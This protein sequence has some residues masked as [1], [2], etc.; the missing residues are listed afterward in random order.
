MSDESKSGW[1]RSVWAFPARD[2]ASPAGLPI[3]RKSGPGGTSTLCSSL[4]SRS[5]KCPGAAAQTM[6]RRRSCRSGSKST[7]VAPSYSKPSPWRSYRL[8]EP[9]SPSPHSSDSLARGPD[10]HGSGLRTGLRVARG[11]A[12]FPRWH[13]RKEFRKRARPHHRFHRYRQHP[14]SGRRSR[15]NSGRR[16]GCPTDA[17]GRAGARGL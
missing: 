1:R 3:T 12:H 2:A 14:R 6:T 4:R 7:A 8:A 5:A 11:D 13:R 9:S 16:G 10:N 17:H 15:A